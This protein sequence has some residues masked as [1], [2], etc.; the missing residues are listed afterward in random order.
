MQTEQQTCLPPKCEIWSICWQFEKHTEGV[1]SKMLTRM[2]YD[3]VYGKENQWTIKASQFE[4]RKYLNKSSSESRT[5]R[6]V[7]AW[8]SLHHAQTKNGSRKIKYTL[9]LFLR[10]IIF[11]VV[12]ANQA[13]RGEWDSASRWRSRALRNRALSNKA[14]E[15]ETT[16][17]SICEV[18]MEGFNSAKFT[19]SQA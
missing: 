10:I 4:L 2:G 12:S 11:Q 8:R 7:N 5:W 15:N 17:S 1:G 9:F 3:R 13:S 14:E 19:I 6:L 18:E 16:L